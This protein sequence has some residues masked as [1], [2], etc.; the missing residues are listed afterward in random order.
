[1]NAFWE[2]VASNVI[3]TFIGAGLALFTSFLVIRHSEVQNDLRLLQALI[4]RLYRSRALR[5][6]QVQG[7]F[8]EAAQENE[9]RS[10]KSIL[11]TRNRIALTSDELSSHSD[12]FDE[13]DRMHVAC[14][15]YLNQTEDDPSGYITSLMTLRAELAP[16]VERLCARYKALRWRE[17]GAADLRDRGGG[18]QPAPPG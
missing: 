7:V 10:T 9:R 16:E 13:L 14:L 18:E 8:D 5:A 4:D 3:G 15:R 1:M 6:G 2:S 12:A 11:A 17:V